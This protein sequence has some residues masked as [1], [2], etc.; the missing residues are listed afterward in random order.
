MCPTVRC[1]PHFRPPPCLWVEV[2]I[3]SYFTLRPVIK[4]LLVLVGWVAVVSRSQSDWTTDCL[5]LETNLS[6]L[7]SV[8]FYVNKLFSSLNNYILLFFPLLHSEYK[9]VLPQHTPGTHSPLSA[10]LR[11]VSSTL[12]LTSTAMSQLA[13]ASLTCVCVKWHTPTA[14]CSRGSSVNG[15]KQSEGLGITENEMFYEQMK[16]LKQSHTGPSIFQSCFWDSEAYWWGRHIC[17]VHLLYS[18]ILLITK[19]KVC[20]WFTTFELNH[21]HRLHRAYSKWLLKTYNCCVITIPQTDREF[22]W[23]SFVNFN[24]TVSHDVPVDMI[25]MLLIFSVKK[26]KKKRLQNTSIDIKVKP[27]NKTALPEN[28]LVSCEHSCKSKTSASML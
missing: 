17:S 24:C 1:C 18:A 21:V 3:W 11:L 2:H 4:R 12:H 23:A 15:R 22:D 25:Y 13:K 27:E 10:D 9:Q 6:W 26:K 19:S 16:G 7:T 8:F 14:T 28:S 20:A 5:F